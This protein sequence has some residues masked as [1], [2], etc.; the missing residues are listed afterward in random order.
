MANALDRWWRDL[1]E[2]DP[3]VVVEAGAGRGALAK[4]VLDADPECAPALRYVLVERSAEL[5]RQQ[6]DA[7]PLELPAFVLGPVAVPDDPDEPPT[8]A[9]GTG[10]VA[11]AL[12]ELPAEPVTGVLL[13][14]ELLDNLGFLLL[15]R[16]ADWW[17]EVRVGEHDGALVEVAVPAAPDLAAEAERLAPGAPAGG[18]IPLQTAARDWVRAALSSLER[19][20]LVIIDYADTTPSLAAR[21]WTEWVRTYRDHFPGGKPLDR[22]GSQDLTCEVA[23][24]QLPRPTMVTTQAEF[25]RSHGIDTF[26]AVASETWRQRAAIGD[27]ESLEARSRVNE[28]AALTDPAGLGAFRVL[29]W[30]S[31]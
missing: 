31:A 14:N 23:L 16:S 5:R 17:L 1:G 26:V 29:E 10:P 7:I 12:A 27:L 13:A 2:P 30:V 6:A 18:R 24:D 25:L 22:P 11:T 4:A 9:T 3:Y 21:P 28:A 15:E 19:G 20:R 8:H